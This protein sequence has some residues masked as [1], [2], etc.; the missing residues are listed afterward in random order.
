MQQSI[1]LDDVIASS[2]K[3]TCVL[4]YNAKKAHDLKTAN[5]RAPY[6]A[7]YV[8]LAFR[9]VNGKEMRVRIK[10]SEQLIGSSAKAPYS[11]DDEALP[12]KINIS[13][14]SLDRSDI[15]GG[16][17]VP[18]VR[19]TNDR[20][21]I[22]DTRMSNNIDRYMQNNAKL[23]KVLEII[24]SSYKTVCEEIKSKKEGEFSFRVKKDRKQTDVPVFSIKQVTRMDIDTNCDEKLENPIFRLNMP[25]CKKD[26]R[27]GM[28]SNYYNKFRHTVFDARKMNKKNNYQP[29]PAKVKVDGKLKDLDVSNVGSF[30]TYKSLVGGN[31]SFDSIVI[32]KFGLSLKNSFY[33]LYV[34][35]HKA[36]FSQ[37]ILTKED[38]IKMRGGASEEDEEDDDVEIDNAADES[39]ENDNQ[40]NSNAAPPDSEDDDEEEKSCDSDNVE[41]SVPLKGLSLKSGKRSKK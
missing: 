18:R 1:T 30:I 3:F 17:Y 41:E 5:P 40:D 8:P 34:Y 31:M 37:P 21:V 22:E 16:D 2:E 35:R 6:D 25:V 20:Q 29:V 4:T 15:E 9:H 11:S 27:I 12:K 13:F 24:D 26:G 33:D 32:S 7:T 19:D 23:L 38:I 10:F 14:V 28:W 36:K 39:T